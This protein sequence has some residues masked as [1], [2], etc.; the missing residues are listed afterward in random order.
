MKLILS[1]DEI[2]L[3]LIEVP[4]WQ[5]KNNSLVRELSAANFI[6]AIGM[7]NSIAIAAE[8]IDHHPDILIYSWNKIRVTTTSHDMGGLTLLDFELAKK[9]DEINFIF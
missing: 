6:S 7:I 4:L 8:T 3:Y 5:L 1:E 9:I 2:N